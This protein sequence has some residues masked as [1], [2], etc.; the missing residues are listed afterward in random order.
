MMCSK[1]LTRAWIR[2]EL[3]KANEA[4]CKE[5]EKRMQSEECFT[6]ILEFFNKRSKM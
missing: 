1:H 3:H 2:K 4:E 5:L 6:A